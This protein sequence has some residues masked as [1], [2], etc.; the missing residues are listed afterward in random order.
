MASNLRNASSSIFALTRGLSRAAS[1]SKIQ[2]S[3]WKSYHGSIRPFTFLSKYAMANSTVKP[4]VDINSC[5]KCCVHTEGDKEMVNFLQ[6]EIDNEKQPSTLR[7]PGFD[8]ETNNAHV[9][10][11]KEESGEKIAVR[12]NVNASVDELP[13]ELEEEEG[14]MAS[15]PNFTV[16]ISKDG[17]A[18]SLALHC[19]FPNSGLDDEYMQEAQGGDQQRAHVEFVEVS[20][21]KGMGENADMSAD[22][23]DSKTYTLDARVLDPNL[24]QMFLHMMAERNLGEKFMEDLQ[25]FSTEYE[26]Q[27]Y[28]SFLKKLQ[29]WASK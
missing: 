27:L 20:I 15:C 13:T 5:T 9:V 23:S 18:T 25:D 8:V 16:Y 26:Q 4:Q 6:Q 17:G 7:F 22:L 11:T 12:W 28:V 19:G 21:T 1:Y 3:P 29:S 24:Y 2:S 10:L 14:E